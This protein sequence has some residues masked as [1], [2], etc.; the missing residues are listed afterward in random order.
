[1]NVKTA[2]AAITAAL[3]LA[4]AS[5]ALA[6]VGGPTD[7]QLHGTGS[8]DNSF[9]ITATVDAASNADG[10]NPTGFV[11]MTL[12]GTPYS[13]TVTCLATNGDLSQ[14]VFANSSPAS[15]F[16]KSVT[17]TFKDVEGGPDKADFVASN[18]VVTTCGAREA[19]FSLSSGDF[20][21]V[22]RN[23]APTCKMTAVRKE[24]PSAGGK[25]TADVTVKSPGGLS[26][27]ANPVISNGSLSVPD[28]PAGTT[29]PV[30]VTATKTDQSQLTRFRFGAVNMLGTS[31]FCA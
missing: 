26:A 30:I 8:W 1:M 13:G 24:D 11:S 29:D 20:T 12:N 22:D 15:S 28:F 5:P 2:A 16:F 21:I 27:I 6:A 25:D 23:A 18:Q 17:L 3:T 10:T 19:V 9:P 7:N 31:K 14:V 4:G